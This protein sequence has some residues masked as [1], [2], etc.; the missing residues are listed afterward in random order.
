MQISTVSSIC[1]NDLVKRKLKSCRKASE[2]FLKFKKKL[3]L[4]PCKIACDE[5]DIISSL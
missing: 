3:G 5:Q 4:D 2:R 1:R